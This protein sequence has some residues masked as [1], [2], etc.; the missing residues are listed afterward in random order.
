MAGFN[1]LSS[2]GLVRHNISLLRYD[3]KVRRQIVGQL[4]RLQNNLVAQLS[5]VSFANAAQKA[6]LQSLLTQTDKLI[7]NAYKGINTHMLGEMADL[8]AVESGFAA[9]SLNNL[10]KVDIL[11]AGL[12]PA[13]LRTLAKDS[14]ILGAPA[15]EWWGRQSANMRKRFA[16]EMRQGFLLGEST[17]DLVRRVRGTATGARTTVEI[18]GKARSVPV[19]DGGIMNVSTRE[20]EALV[21]TSVQSV[22]NEA[23]LATYNANTDVI[24]SV[25]AQVTLDNRTSQTCQSYGARPD[26]WTLPDYEPVGGSNHFIGPP[27]WHWNCRSSLVPITKSWQELQTQGNGPK[28]TPKQRKIA[29]KLDNNVAKSTRASMNGQVPKGTGYDA[30]LK[31]QPAYIQKEA[32]G[33]TK[34]ELWKKGHLNLSQMLDQTGRPMTL[35]RLAGQTDA[36]TNLPSGSAI[37]RAKDYAETGLFNV[38]LKD[39]QA[40]QI[41][42]SKADK[43]WWELTPEKNTVLLGKTRP[44]AIKKLET[45]L[46]GGT[47]PPTPPVK[48]KA[49]KKTKKKTTKKKKGA[50]NENGTWV[51]RD[52]DFAHNGEYIVTLRDG[53]QF[54]MYRDQGTGWWYEA[55]K[56]KLAPRQ[57][58]IGFTREEA[59][60]HFE[61]R[62]FGKKPPI[63]PKTPP[64]KPKP[65]PKTKTSE[66]PAAPVVEAT[67]YRSLKIDDVFKDANGD[68]W[69]VFKKTSRTIRC[70]K[71]SKTRG[72]FLTGQGKSFSFTSAPAK[73]VKQF[74]QTTQATEGS[75][76]S[77]FKTSTF[78][79][80]IGR[81]FTTM[82][83]KALE[84]SIENM[85]KNGFNPEL[86]KLLK[87]KKLEAHVFNA[88][89]IK[90]KVNLFGQRDGGNWRGA[91]WNDYRA[92]GM[93]SDMAHKGV[94]KQVWTHE[95]GHHIDYVV[96]RHQYRTLGV[97]KTDTSAL[98]PTAAKLFKKLNTAYTDMHLE[99]ESV[100]RQMAKKLG[101][102]KNAS[103][104]LSSKEQK[105]FWYEIDQKRKGMAPSS[106]SLNN[107]KEWYAEQFASYFNLRGTRVRMAE[108]NPKTYN[109]FETLFSSEMELLWKELG[110]L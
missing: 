66:P 49:P 20:A 64:V 2:D 67:N 87:K 98:S 104:T 3:A 51:V 77:L 109:F 76:E 7:K 103:R 26:E 1:D 16:D 110:A 85:S 25:Q 101:L 40:F 107:S 34:R 32:L 60:A 21:R 5:D 17:G 80:E 46:K 10:F 73:T 88:G 8:A 78:H 30:W 22:A 59:V 56:S 15:K 69:K 100:S 43:Q 108:W 94:M 50:T 75:L 71:W 102:S 70:F 45:R 33:V 82:Q 84:E 105:K 9:K 35:Q 58:Q 81:P 89:P 63:K 24:K 55:T 57:L 97:G 72:R 91:Y 36:L 48:P 12:T 62:V 95:F 19:F 92:L 86:A 93:T 11:S 68:T 54:R 106:Y 61:R 23:R 27:P 52:P 39:G 29:K 47:P 4:R 37:R 6:R 65:K 74:A 38:T 28:A 79:K 31:K 18:A 14:N 42:R 90:G 96:N 13:A 41:F 99:Y 53:T 83:T 44:A